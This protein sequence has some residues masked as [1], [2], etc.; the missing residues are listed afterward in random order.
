MYRSVRVLSSSDNNLAIDRARQSHICEVNYT[1]DRY[2]RHHVCSQVLLLELLRRWPRWR[3]VRIVPVNGLR[4]LHFCACLLSTE[5]SLILGTVVICGTTLLSV[6]RR[7]IVLLV[8]SASIDFLLRPLCRD[9]RVV[10]CLSV[11]EWSPTHPSCTIVW[12]LTGTLSATSAYPA[13]TKLVVDSL[14]CRVGSE[15]T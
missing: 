14:G 3:L 5:V 13:M 6:L 4:W 7:R 1:N 2:R 11:T 8:V 9:V 10:G 12:L 15:R